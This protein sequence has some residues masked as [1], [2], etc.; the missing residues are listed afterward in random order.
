MKSE[1]LAGLETAGD[2][3][4]MR[5]SVSGHRSVKPIKRQTTKVHDNLKE[6]VNPL[7]ESQFDMRKNLPET[8]PA[9]ESKV[10][11]NRLS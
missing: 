5:D 6:M 8:N 9:E 2:T 3:E 1:M 7:T 11:Q 10:S 4:N